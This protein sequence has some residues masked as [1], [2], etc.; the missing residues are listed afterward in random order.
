MPTA[1]INFHILIG[2]AESGPGRDL[3]CTIVGHEDP[4]GLALNKEL[5]ADYGAEVRHGCLYPNLDRLVTKD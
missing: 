3:L 1:T 5:E 2:E 4:H